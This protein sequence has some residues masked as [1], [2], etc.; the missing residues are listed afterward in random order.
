[1]YCFFDGDVF[2]GM[3]DDSDNVMEIIFKKSDNSVDF[4]SE[5]TG[6]F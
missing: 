3:S 4:S 5:E 2:Y 1:M 6:N